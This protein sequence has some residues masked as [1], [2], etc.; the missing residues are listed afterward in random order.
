MKLCFCAT[1]RSVSAVLKNRDQSGLL[2]STSV[3]RPV[4]KVIPA[5]SH[6]MVV[7]MIVSAALES[8]RCYSQ[9]LADFF[10]VMCSAITAGFALATMHLRVIDVVAPMKS[11]QKAMTISLELI[12]VIMFRRSEC[13]WC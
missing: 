4:R 5:W 6:V 12:E 7:L 2:G 9:R 10:V 3:Q 8:W 1:V 11:Q 13:L